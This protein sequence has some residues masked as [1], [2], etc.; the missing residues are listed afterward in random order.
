MSLL[1]PSPNARVR[2]RW[3][4]GVL[5][6]IAIEIV[7]FQFVPSLG[8]GAVGATSGTL[9]Y[10]VGPIG[11][12]LVAGVILV[13]ALDWWR[14]V[15]FEARRTTKR[16]LLLV[17][18]LLVGIVLLLTTGSFQSSAKS[19]SL[20][21]IAILVFVLV[22]AASEEIVFRGILLIG[23]RGSGWPEWSVYLTSTTLF[24]G[25]HLG[26]VFAGIPIGEV[27]TQML[28]SFLL[29]TVLYLVRRSS[30]NLLVAIAVHALFN[31]SILFAS[32]IGAG[33][34]A[35]VAGGVII[36]AVQVL[37]IPLVVLLLILDARKARRTAP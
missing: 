15:F 25:I 21:V 4:I 5:F 36:Q 35:G 19:D 24:A 3:W 16:W 2:P 9:G 31:S 28:S 13:A 30:G 17:G 32:E 29:G 14:P 1:A 20:Y 6:F 33:S 12:S 7:V 18:V 34:P 10:L 37:S 8:S 22:A 23:F 11:I 26:N 27:I